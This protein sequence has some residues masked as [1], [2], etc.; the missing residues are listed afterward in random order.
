[1]PYRIKM[2]CSR[3]CRETDPRGARPLSA[4]VM[5]SAQVLA[6]S[7]LKIRI[8]CL[9]A[10]PILQV[11]SALKETEAGGESAESANTKVGISN[12]AWAVFRQ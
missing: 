8:V 7:P 3:R 1:M 6:G 2:G 12:P 9:L 5:K 11:F 10:W 4:W